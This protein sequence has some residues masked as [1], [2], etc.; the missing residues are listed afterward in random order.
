MCQQLSWHRASPLP[1][2]TRACNAILQFDGSYMN[3]RGLGVQAT[4]MVPSSFFGTKHTLH[5]MYYGLCHFTPRGKVNLEA[6]RPNVGVA[7][8]HRTLYQKKQANKS[9]QP[10]PKTTMPHTVICYAF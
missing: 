4:A 1:G 9:Q 5:L 8:T 6:T 2:T 7:C 3:M 10:K